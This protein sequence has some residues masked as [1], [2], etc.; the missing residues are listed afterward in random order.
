MD[1]YGVL[2]FLNPGFE[3]VEALLTDVAENLSKPINTSR[4]YFTI[5]YVTH[6]SVH[7]LVL[8]PAQRLAWYKETT[9]QIYL[10]LTMPGGMKGSS[11]GLFWASF[12]MVPPQLWFIRVFISPSTVRRQVSFGLPL[13]CSPCYQVFSKARAQLLLLFEPVLR[14]TI[15]C[16]FVSGR[17]VSTRKHFRAS[18]VSFNRARAMV[19]QCW[20]NLLILTAGFVWSDSQYKLLA[21]HDQ[22]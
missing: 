17:C 7:F 18:Q 5:K 15:R 9:S 1:F 12:R 8:L 20:G 19:S 3:L 14:Y 13:L 22:C 21:L 16:Y 6:D 11:E 4:R 2:Q 10:L